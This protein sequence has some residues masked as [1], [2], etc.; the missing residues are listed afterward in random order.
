MSKSPWTKSAGVGFCTLV[1]AGFFSFTLNRLQVGRTCIGV[2]MPDGS[3]SRA[4]QWV[5]LRLDCRTGHGRRANISA[6]RRR[7]RCSR[8]CS[9]PTSCASTTTS[10]SC[11]HA[12]SASSCLLPSSWPQERSRRTSSFL[13]LSLWVTSDSRS[14]VCAVRSIVITSPS[15]GVQSIAISVSVCLSAR[16]SEKS[17]VQ[18]SQNF[19]YMLPMAVARFSSDNRAIRYV[20]PA[21]VRTRLNSLTWLGWVM[22]ELDQSVTQ[23]IDWLIHVFWLIDWLIDWLVL[24]D[25]GH[26]SLNTSSKVASE[27]ESLRN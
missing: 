5:C 21:A 6:S 13:S 17:H 20:V 23:S 18:T 3:V 8:H 9:I 4:V 19:L 24:M 10:R 14:C 11:R 27:S 1:S 16:I 2:L 26:A 7:R 15:L 22:C 25:W 12:A